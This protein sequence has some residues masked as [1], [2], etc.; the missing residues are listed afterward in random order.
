MGWFLVRF[1]T[2]RIP[3][4]DDKKLT[5]SRLKRVG[6]GFPQCWPQ[7]LHSIWQ[8]L[9]ASCIHARRS[10]RFLSSV[11]PSALDGDGCKNSDVNDVVNDIF[12]ESCDFN[13]N[14]VSRLSTFHLA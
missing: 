12:R 1:F 14:S 7:M 5:F 4:A 3:T 10:K 8:S 6:A 13:L 11:D 9:D 2:S